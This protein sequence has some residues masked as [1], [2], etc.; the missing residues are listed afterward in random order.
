MEMWETREKSLKA[1]TNELRIEGELIYQ[2]FNLM[3][4]IIEAF[5]Q[6]PTPSE[7]SRVC[8][9]VVA[10]GRNLCHCIFSISLEGLAQEAGALLRPTIECFEL[11]VFF[12]QDPTRIELAL[13]NKLPEAGKIAKTIQGKFQGLRIYLNT[14]ASHMSVSD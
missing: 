4:E 13:K 10:K 9:L 14:Y 2:G 6:T 7:C 1:L 5:N 3:D 11:L 12:Y 8:G